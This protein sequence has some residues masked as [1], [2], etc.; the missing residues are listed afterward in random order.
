VEFREQRVVRLLVALRSGRVVKWLLA[1]GLSG[2]AVLVRAASRQL[3]LWG[4]EPASLV[5]RRLVDTLQLRRFVATST[6]GAF[7]A[8]AGTLSIPVRGSRQV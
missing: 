7:T 5:S 1:V 4:L 3:D 8:K 2:Q 6:I